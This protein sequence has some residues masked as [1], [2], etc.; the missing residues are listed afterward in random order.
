LH[1]WCW[2][3]TTHILHWRASSEHSLNLQSST[4]SHYCYRCLLDL[5]KPTV[6]SDIRILTS[7]SPAPV[8][9]ITHSPS[10]HDSHSD[11]R[12]GTSAAHSLVTPALTAPV[13]T[14]TSSYNSLAFLYWDTNE[15]FWQLRRKDKMAPAHFR[16]SANLQKICYTYLILLKKQN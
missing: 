14:V 1:A 13:G 6:D 8:N 9:V 3:S 10:G 15:E 16:V 5:N 2:A 7:P 11:Y 12:S 4:S